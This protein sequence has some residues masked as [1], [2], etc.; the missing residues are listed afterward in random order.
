MGLKGLWDGFIIGLI[1]DNILL[2]YLTV[3]ADWVA[4]YALKSEEKSSEI[5]LI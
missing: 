5:T 2:C 4:K 3:K 1:F